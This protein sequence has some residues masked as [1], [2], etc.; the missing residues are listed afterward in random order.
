MAY[1]RDLLDCEQG[2]AGYRSNLKDCNAKD[3]R[4]VI[5]WWHERGLSSRSVGRRLSTI[6]QFMLW[7]VE[8]GFRANNPT[9]WIDNPS[10]PK[11]LPKSLTE[12]EI[13]E[14]I[15]ATSTLPSKTE[16]FRARAMLEILYATGL[17]VS[18]LINLKVNQFKR[19]PEVIFIIG[20]GGRERILPL[21]EM[22]RDVAQRWLE[23]RD[24]EKNFLLSDLMFPDDAGTKMS[25]QKFSQILKKLASFSGIDKSRVSPHKLRHSFA[26]HMLNRGADL[27]SIQS[28]LGHA[29]ISTT[30]IYTA[31]RPERLSG[32]VKNAHPLASSQQD[33]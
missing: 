22:A 31:T 3:L 21:G 30:Q 19:N 15:E 7:A 4:K 28:L 18:E 12:I 8:S 29:S 17:R 11:T 25:R 2:L 32:L 13:K 16:A 27:R 24:A 6:R 10:V 9:H 14:L 5:S 33:K 1:R 20:K 26:S 23:F